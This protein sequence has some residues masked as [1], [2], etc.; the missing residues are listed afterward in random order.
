MTLATV[1]I[2]FVQEGGLAQNEWV[3]GTEDVLQYALARTHPFDSAFG[4]EV[5]FEVF[6]TGTEP[7]GDFA[8]TQ[9]RYGHDNDMDAICRETFGSCWRNTDWTDLQAALRSGADV[10][11]IQPQEFQN[12]WTTFNGTAYWL[13]ERRYFS[14]RWPVHSGYLVH[15]RLDESGGSSGTPVL[16]MGSWYGDYHV[17]CTSRPQS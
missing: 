12:A 8:Y 9:D 3:L 11:S 14:S 13:G 2:P 4:F 16:V 15:H 1:A 5:E 10:E 17:S 6:V 7:R